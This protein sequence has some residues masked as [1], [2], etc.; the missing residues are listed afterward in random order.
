MP[1]PE[2]DFR[3]TRASVTMMELRGQPGEVFDR[4][5]HGMTVDVEKAGKK[6]G[7]IVPPDA[8]A[9]T[10]IVHRDGTIS[11]A[12]PLTFRLDLGSKY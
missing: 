1:L 2:K 3:G 10:T 7:T 11:G 5:S 8:D 12:I 4:V 9:D 6:V